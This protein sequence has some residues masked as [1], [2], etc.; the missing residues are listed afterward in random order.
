MAGTEL[1]RLRVFEQRKD[2]PGAV[3]YPDHFDA[4]LNGTIEDNVLSVRE[5]AKIGS[6]FR[7]GAS[8][9]G[10]A[11]QSLDSFRDS[12]EEAVSGVWVALGDIQGRVNEVEP[13]LG[14][15]PDRAHFAE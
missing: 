11:R 8:E 7:A 14:S 13:S 15:A 12:V 4:T 10:M 2:V 9:Q 1:R 5:T 6:E 3:Q